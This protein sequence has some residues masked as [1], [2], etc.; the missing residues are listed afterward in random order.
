MVKPPAAG[1]RLTSKELSKVSEALEEIEDVFASS[2]LTWDDPRQEAAHNERQPIANV[3]AKVAHDEEDQD[4]DGDDS[5]NDDDHGEGYYDREEI[6]V[7]LANFATTLI[8]AKVVHKSK[9]GDPPSFTEIFEKLFGETHW[10][11]EKAQSFEDFVEGYFG[12]ILP[13]QMNAAHEAFVEIRGFVTSKL[14]VPS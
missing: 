8:K 6:E 1:R 2:G 7:A 13:E 5:D 4:A 10:I 9:N 11:V 12:R 3:D 14:K